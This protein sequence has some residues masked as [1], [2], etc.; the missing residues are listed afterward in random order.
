MFRCVIG[1]ADPH[2]P[3][4]RT[5]RNV[6]KHTPDL[7]ADGILLRTATITSTPVHQRGQCGTT[8]VA[9]AASNEGAARHSEKVNLPFKKELELAQQFSS[10]YRESTTIFSSYNPTPDTVMTHNVDVLPSGAAV[11]P[12]TAQC[13]V[14]L[15]PT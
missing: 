15:H 5:F 1:R 6:G 7:T 11:C 8:N 2:V 9:A 10:R 3:K 12:C 14:L 4:N 13:H